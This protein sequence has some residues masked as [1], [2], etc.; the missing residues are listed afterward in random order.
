[1]HHTITLR[2]APGGLMLLASTIWPL[3][4]S[5]NFSGAWLCVVRWQESTTSVCGVKVVCLIVCTRLAISHPNWSV[6]TSSCSPI[7][8]T[9]RAK[10]I[11]QL[12]LAK[13]GMPGMTSLFIWHPHQNLLQLHV[14]NPDRYL[15][16]S[17]ERKFSAICSLESIPYVGPGCVLVSS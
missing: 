11:L 15:H 13:N 10:Y 4:L 7:L 14:S 1:M 6:H 8:T 16:Y 5:I 9:G 12:C 17:I 3:R 2:L